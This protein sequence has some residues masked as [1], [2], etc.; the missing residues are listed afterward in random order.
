MTLALSHFSAVILF[1]AFASIIFGI[2]QRSTPRA[3]AVRNRAGGEVI[4]MHLANQLWIFEQ[5][6]RGPE[7][8]A[9]VGPSS[10]QLRRQS[11]VEDDDII[12]FKKGCD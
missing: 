7:R 4:V 10:L 5:Q 3:M 2:T 8:I 1:A 12:L 9:Q 11:A 6:L